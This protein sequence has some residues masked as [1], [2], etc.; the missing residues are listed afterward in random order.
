MSVHGRSF[1]Q[2][3]NDDDGVWV[4]IPTGDLVGVEYTDKVYE[5][6]S[7]ELVIS[8]KNMNRPLGT[9]LDASSGTYTV[10][11]TAQATAIGVTN[12]TFRRF[13]KIRL[14]HMPRPL[15]PI[16]AVHDSHG[17]QATF[18]LVAHGL[19]AG[20]YVQ[21]VNDSSGSIDDD[22]YR[23]DI[24]VDV[25]NVKLDQRGT[26]ASSQTYT[27]SLP[28]GG[29]TATTLTGTHSDTAA[30]VLTVGDTTGINAGDHIKI[31][32]EIIRVTTVASGTVLN[33]VVRARFSTT[34][35]SHTGGV[36]VTKVY[37][38][39]INYRSD[40]AL[41]PYFYGRIDTVD[42]SYSD[43]VGKTIH[44][45]A[46]DYLRNLQNEPLTKAILI[47][48]T[49]SQAFNESRMEV[50]E[51]SEEAE[52]VDQGKF[53][54]ARYTNRKL[55]D[56]VKEITEDWSMGDDNSIIHADNTYD[57]STSIGES[58]LEASAHEYRATDPMRVK[59][60]YDQ[61]IKAL[62]AMRSV[63]MN[64]PH[65]NNGYDTFDSGSEVEVS[66]GADGA[67]VD[68]GTVDVLIKRTAHGYEN[69]NIVT[70]SLYDLQGDSTSPTP[71]PI[72]TGA[73]IVHTVA[74]NSFKL[75]TLDGTVVQSVAN[76]STA[77]TV[78]IS[79]QPS[80][81]LG[82][83]FWLDAGLYGAATLT[84][85]THRPHLNYFMRGTR[86][87]DP[88][89]TGLSA[90]YPTEEN[91][92]GNDAAFGAKGSNQTK[93]FILD[94][95]DHGLYEEDLY[96]QV[97][98]QAVNADGTAS[99]V[100]SLGHKMEMLQVNS[101]SD[102]DWVS[103]LTTGWQ[104][105]SGSLYGNALF[106]WN[107]ADDGRSYGWYT[108][109][110]PLLTCASVNTVN[111]NFF[112][113]PASLSTQNNVSNN[114]ESQTYGSQGTFGV[115]TAGV[116]GG[117]TNDEVTGMGGL[118]N[119][120]KGGRPLT[121]SPTERDRGRKHGYDG[122]KQGDDFH[123]I[124]GVDQSVANALTDSVG[125][126]GENQIYMGAE[127]VAPAHLIKD[128]YWCEQEGLLGTEVTDGT[129]NGSDS[130]IIVTTIA[131][132]GLETGTIVK[133]TQIDS[134]TTGDVNGIKVNTAPT[135]S[136][137]VNSDTTDNGSYFRVVWVSATT[138]SLTACQKH[139]IDIDQADDRISFSSGL[140]AGAFRYKP[141]FNVF[142]EACRVQWQSGS[143]WTTKEEDV[144][145]RT[146]TGGK[147]AQ[148]ILISDVVRNDR[149]YRGLEVNTLESGA[150]LPGQDFTDNLK[151]PTHHYDTGT[152]EAA[153]YFG[154][155]TVPFSVEADF[156]GGGAST[157][158]AN[159]DRYGTDSDDDVAVRFRYGD[160]VSETRFLY[161]DA[162]LTGVVGRDRSGDPIVGGA[163]KT[164]NDV[165]KTVK[166]KVL[167]RFSDHASISKT[168]VY[169]YNVNAEAADSV[170]QSVANILQRVIIPAQRTTFKIFGYP[171]IKFVG[172][173]QSGSSGSSLVTPLAWKSF[174]GRAGML[175]EKTD[176]TDG[177]TKDATLVSAINA[178][179]D[180]VTAPIRGIM[181]LAA[182]S[183]T[184]APVTYFRAYVHLRA[185][186]SIRVVH[187]A[188]GITSNMI[189][190]AL[191]YSERAGTAHTTI[192]T[193]GYDEALINFRFTAL[194][195][196][197]SSI[198]ATG[199]TADPETVG[200]SDYITGIA[201][202][203]FDDE[204]SANPVQAGL[205]T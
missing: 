167:K 201:V 161:G 181:G 164:S 113:D 154:Y 109:A 188:A 87:I 157:T 162:A 68:T 85:N 56:T 39:Y 63:A 16:A 14:L 148:E 186:S 168:F 172:A 129:H 55:S 58:K 97:A 196:L 30:T 140:L 45:R 177:I 190:T 174:G 197:R 187:P 112:A 27:T 57:G 60:F 114:E 9:S 173:A 4:P 35:A 31:D 107:R 205:I 104:S 138:F 123:D 62:G 153:S 43:A 175:V 25:N 119:L 26:G 34:A 64:D 132:H 134:T 66:Y 195:N 13:Q 202:Q 65:S 128:I 19:S 7:V 130:A 156:A 73:Y 117:L 84:S 191:K 2:Y 28:G 120:M 125:V 99:D 147:G 150:N 160:Y 199:N 151:H 78:A 11:G 1:L 198:A 204:F 96:T 169:Q 144:V 54:N 139:K 158:R 136:G 44:I 122:A 21:I 61:D 90:I 82:Y 194:G 145:L 127:G 179:T 29:P 88:G 101:M 163:V 41:Y 95:F 152:T 6:A 80:G 171:T 81:A 3:Y 178:T 89:T 23:V 8:N 115:V 159:I 15:T 75:K 102:S 48:T 10:E 182:D 5:P 24:V 49:T 22:L 18:T 40:F 37:P 189:I 110:S 74:T 143:D 170:R 105:H 142:K 17:T 165:F 131:N 203:R 180:V 200:Y 137:G 59:T 183:W 32:D 149:P 155:S 184:T 193:T 133:V 79:P 69:G 70:V 46:S 116:L 111:F 71:T 108:V 92:E 50:G 192:S 121:M 166:C 12:P 146:E 185:G 94:N 103:G 33:P 86:P 52:T 36:A 76:A 118:S 141:V 53:R 83:D 124:N 93:V 98:L 47:S 100:N 126:T 67:E 176:A 51:S 72:T 135:R 106:H 38:A 20:D 91:L 42:V 77:T